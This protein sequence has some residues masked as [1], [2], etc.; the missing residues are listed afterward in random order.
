MLAI[1]FATFWPAVWPI[2]IWRPSGGGPPLA[3]AR[4]RRSLKNA[5][6]K[7]RR[8]RCVGNRKTS[9]LK[10][11]PIVGGAVQEARLRACGPG[12][13]KRQFT[14]SD[15]HDVVDPEGG[16][17]LQNARDLGEK[18][19]LVLDVH[20]YVQ[21][22]GAVETAI[23]KRQFEG[24]AL[25]IE[26][27]LAQA[28]A[29]GERLRG[30]D[31]FLG[32]VDAGDAAAASIGE[33][34]RPAPEPGTD[35]QEV[36]AVPERQIRR[37]I[38]GR[39]AAADVEF[40]DR[41]EI[42]WRQALGILS[43]CHDGVEDGALQLAVRVVLRD[44][45]LDDSGHRPLRERRLEIES[46]HRKLGPV[47]AFAHS[48]VNVSGAGALEGHLEGDL[49]GVVAA[50]FEGGDLERAGDAAEVRHDDLVALDRA[51]EEHLAQARVRG[52]VLEHAGAGDGGAAH[53]RLAEELAP[54]PG[55]FGVRHV[56]GLG[57]EGELARAQARHGNEATGAVGDLDEKVLAFLSGHDAFLV[58][59]RVLL[60]PPSRGRASRRGSG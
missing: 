27:P 50:I 14:F 30:T 21:H 59:L 47:H 26:D 31:V 7:S 29:A 36:T 39:L 58:E 9:P 49:A 38:R 48:A 44:A 13:R 53:A 6:A 15:P 37:E 18:L 55:R 60:A 56:D 24:A 51:V 20:A 52:L 1:M 12:H 25:P 11:P 46:L 22:V 35:V 10:Q 33:I 3:A 43:G 42:R 5:I 32:E 45:V 16:G 41:P 8:L 54:A 19:T 40:V 4:A 28:H 2:R 57:I 23:G 17:G 34:P